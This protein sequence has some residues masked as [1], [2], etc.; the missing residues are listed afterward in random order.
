M[1]YLLLI[2]KQ[3]NLPPEKADVLNYKKI[4]LICLSLKALLPYYFLSH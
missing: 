3:K 1:I 4:I 2:I